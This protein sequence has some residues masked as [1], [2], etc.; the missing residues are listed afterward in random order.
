MLTHEERLRRQIRDS[1]R[2]KAADVA[3]GYTVDADRVNEG[4][5]IYSRSDSIASAIV[6]ALALDY[7]VVRKGRPQRTVW[8]KR[9]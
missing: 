8:R 9:P 5:L 3:F 7:S 4:R 1:I 6:E 2:L